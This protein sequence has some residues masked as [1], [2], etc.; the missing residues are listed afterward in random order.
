MIKILPLGTVVNSSHSI[1][2]HSHGSFLSWPG[3]GLLQRTLQ[4]NYASPSLSP[5]EA[6]PISPFPSSVGP[7][8]SVCHVLLMI[9][10]SIVTDTI[11]HTDRPTHHVYVISTTTT[12]SSNLI[13]PTCKGRLTSSRP[14]L[15]YSSCS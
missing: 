1:V 2:E 4:I 7:A 6:P 9:H 15:R 5:W 12:L 13:C 14:A 8:L 10:P 11:S 3:R